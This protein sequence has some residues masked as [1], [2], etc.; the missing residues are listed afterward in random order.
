MRCNQTNQQIRCEADVIGRAG[1][2]S[3]AGMIGNDETGALW[4]DNQWMRS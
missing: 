3:V 2:L 4:R 1:G